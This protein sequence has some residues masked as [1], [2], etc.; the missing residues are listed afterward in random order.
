[1]AVLRKPTPPPLA[2]YYQLVIHVHSHILGLDFDD[3]IL[4]LVAGL[5][6]SECVCAREFTGNGIP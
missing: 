5:A 1:V 4:V 3:H 6:A 2:W